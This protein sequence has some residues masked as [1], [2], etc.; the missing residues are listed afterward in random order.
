MAHQRVV[1]I[2]IF[3]AIAAAFLIS[4]VYYPF[5]PDR[6]ASHWNPAGEVDGEMAKLPGLL[7]LPVA[8]LLLA[9]LF[10]L[11]PKMDPLK[12]NIA[13]FRPQYDRFILTFLVYLLAVHVVVILWNAGTKL[14]FNIILP[15]GAGL[16]VFY[17]GTLLQH[18]KRN[19]FIG[20]RTPW[21]LSS[22]A[23]WD[24]THQAGAR[25]FKAAGIIAVA[26]SLFGE[27]AWL[28]ILVPLG[29]AAAWS[30]IYSYI[31]FRQ[32]AGSGPA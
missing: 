10:A 11:I 31:V 20:I 19:Y 15:L 26:G 6:V 17:I 21:T 2:G 24:R 5:A 14:D 25:V 29:A 23:V 12:A 13:K 28:F 1:T 30:I 27:A 22:D 16:L 9:G 32:V 18:V 7:I 3:T 8:M 4:A